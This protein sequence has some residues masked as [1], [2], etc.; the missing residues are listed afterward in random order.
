MARRA[1]RGAAPALLLLLLS[2]C[3]GAGDAEDPLAG[4][5]ADDLFAEAEGLLAE[6]DY[7]EAASLFGEVERRHPH[8]PLAP[9]SLLLSGY[10]HYSGQEYSE[11]I[12]AFERFI[13]LHPGNE[14]I[15]YAYYLNAVCYYEQISDIERDQEKTRLA[16][17]GLNGL[18]ERFPESQYARDARLKRD[19]AYDLLAGKEVSIG[20]F[21][22]EQGA[23]L[24]AVNRFRVV[25]EDYDTTTHAPEALHRL[26]ES[27]LALGLV[28]DA[29]R[30][31]RVLGHNH[32]ASEW[33]RLSHELLTGGELPDDAPLV[34]RSLRGLF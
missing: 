2:A 33:Y 32:P 26:V 1:A 14:Q 12:A 29:R 19:L 34:E 11:A 15:D 10:S 31:G 25:V 13:E 4:R 21:Y 7:D 9:R 22:Q 5:E 28:E 27:Y 23:W 30:A 3:A 6:E 16:L 17:Q 24:A 18:L 8:S 20:R